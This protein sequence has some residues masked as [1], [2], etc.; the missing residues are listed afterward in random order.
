MQSIL[1]LLHENS[2]RGGIIYNMATWIHEIPKKKKE[3]EKGKPWIQIC[4]WY[5]K[6]TK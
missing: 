2:T 6:I 1:R 5:A 3:K 4:Y